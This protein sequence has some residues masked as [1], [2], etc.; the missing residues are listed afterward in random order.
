MNWSGSF[1]LEM[2]WKPLA[3]YFGPKIK[4]VESLAEKRHVN[5]ELFD[6]TESPNDH[7]HSPIG[8]NPPSGIS[9][10]NHIIPTRL[11]RLLTYLNAHYAVPVVI[12]VC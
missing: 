1:K 10:M 4:W 5:Y 12:F 2:K 8:S 7:L 11:V 6:E 9:H 3:G